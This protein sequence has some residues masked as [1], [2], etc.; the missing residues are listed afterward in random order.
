MP[1]ILANPGR[2]RTG[3]IG[4]ALLLGIGLAPPTAAVAA[5]VDLRAIGG[6]ATSTIV[7]GNVAAAQQLAQQRRITIQKS[8]CT[9]KAAGGKALLQNVD[10]FVSGVA[11][12]LNRDDPVLAALEAGTPPGTAQDTCDNHRPSPGPGKQIN[13]CW[14]LARGGKVILNNVS[15][16]TRAG[17]GSTTTRTIQSAAVPP[18]NGGAAAALC[19]NLVNDAL[20]QRDDCTGSGAGGAWSMGGVDVAIHNPDGTTS[21]RRG[22]TVEVRGG[23]AHAGMHCFNVRDAGGVVQINVCNADALGGDATLRN[24]AFHTS[25]Q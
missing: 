10:I 13:K 8:N 11:R 15:L 1:T 21:T 17:D 6:N 23:D 12:A 2:T 20:N 16:V 19:A 18:G 25:A 24:V 7:C 3:V 4:A 5:D 9:A 22:I 14:A